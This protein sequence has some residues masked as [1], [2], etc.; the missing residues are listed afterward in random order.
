MFRAVPQPL[1]LSDLAQIY[2]WRL[3]LFATRL[4]HRLTTRWAPIVLPVVPFLWVP[5]MALLFGALLGW[6]IVR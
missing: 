2:A 4:T 1:P 5:V 3:M 6:S